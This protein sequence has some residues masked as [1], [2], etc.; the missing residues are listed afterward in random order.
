MSGVTTTLKVAHVR[1]CHSR[2]M[3]VRAY[4]RETQEMVFDAH[5]LRSRSSRAPARAASTTIYGRLPRKAIC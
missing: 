4:L 1:L 2:M 3:F 5:D